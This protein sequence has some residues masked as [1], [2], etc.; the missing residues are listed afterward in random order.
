MT[1]T[2]IAS[3]SISMNIIL[4]T[5]DLVERHEIK[6]DSVI[7]DDPA[8]AAA[9][10][11]S[12]DDLDEIPDETGYDNAGDDVELPSVLAARLASVREAYADLQ[13]AGAPGIRRLTQELGSRIQELDLRAEFI[14]RLRGSVE[15]LE[16]NRSIIESMSAGLKKTREA[17]SRL[18]LSNQ[19]LVLWIARKHQ[20]RG[21]PLM[22]L[23]QEGNLG[24]LKAVDRFD[25][26]MGNKFA[27]YAM[28]WI[29]QSITRAIA[30][31]SRL[32]RVPVHMVEL[33]NKVRW[34]VREHEILQGREPT[35][36]ELAAKL[37]IRE[38]KA[39]QALLLLQDAV[40]LDEMD[41][42]EVD[43]YNMLVDPSPSPEQGILQKSREVLI[44][45]EL[46]GMS[47][48]KRT[49]ICRRY[50]IGGGGEQ[51][52]EEIGQVYKVTRERIRQIESNALKQLSHPSRLKKFS[53]LL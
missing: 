33:V 32:I 8:Y 48:Q 34:A 23:V 45:K 31:Q 25:Y 10:A 16:S 29:R 24:L 36:L 53:S 5:F 38:A 11:L 26:S 44:G 7:S 15:T 40:S 43:H 13:S 37:E 35:T 47:S 50:G 18:F 4:E 49:V 1:L 52:L 9:E 28:W 12:G 6:W 3:S 46:S 14:E 20:N 22:D 27:T 2:A 42:I 39:A 21:L 51:T 30:D 41:G 17:K 19:K